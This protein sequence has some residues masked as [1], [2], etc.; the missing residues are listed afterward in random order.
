MF[1][2]LASSLLVL[3]MDFNTIQRTKSSVVSL[4]RE[5][6]A[7][8]YNAVL[9]EVEDKVRWDLPEIAAPDAFTKEEFR[10][11]LAEAD[12]LGLEPI[13]L[14]QVFG[15]G[16]YI[17]T[18]KPYFDLRENPQEPDCYCVSKPEVVAFQK[19]MLDEYLDLFGKKVRYF[20]LGG[21]E[22]YGFAK[23][24]VCRKRDR[25]E[26]YIEH[27]N[28]LSDHLAQHG[29]R[30]GVWHDMITGGA[31][32]QDGAVADSAKVPRKYV[33]WLWDYLV[34]AE[35]GGPYYADK[36]GE[37]RKLGF[38]V[39]LSGA[40]SSFNDG[41]FVPAIRQHR[42]NLAYCAAVARE[43]KLL[44]LA[45]TSWSIR[46]NLRATQMPL[47]RFAAKRYLDPSPAAATDWVAALKA[48]KDL[49]VEPEVLDVACAWGENLTRFDGR[50][51]GLYKD[52][53]K[54]TPADFRKWV[55]EKRA[56]GKIPSDVKLKPI[57]ASL[58]SAMAKSTG[59]WK[60]AFELEYNTL[61]AVEAGVNLRPG[62]P[63]D[64]AKA[65]RHLS[66]EQSP[67]SAENSVGIIWGFY[68]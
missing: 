68:E 47:F 33:V 28:R 18:K 63:M 58:E 13:P 12:R 36:L 50:A 3:H 49:Q 38:D 25:M 16:E 57:F 67:H 14:F 65:L 55:A 4:L 61:K 59:V 19:K 66:R 22:A 60:E 27:L 20:H 62:V 7:M 23:C 10:E 64:R 45:V 32:W 29:I 11:I 6:S 52:G 43:Q 56:T 48:E 53:R 24:D 15:H 37:L 31:W 9:W 34:G 42:L 30:P 44:G 39:I 21:D 40:T 5:A 26:L 54:P 2:L 1:S 41:P 17:L 46:Q 51:F 8:G 35:C